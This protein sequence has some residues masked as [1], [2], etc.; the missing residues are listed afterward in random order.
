MTAVIVMEDGTIIYGEKCG[1]EGTAFGELVFNTSMAGYQEVL[2]DPSYNGQI[3][4]MT[5]PMIGNYGC[6][7]LF[8]ES[9]GGP[10]VKAFVM[11]E[12]CAL[13][14][15]WR[16]ESSLGDYLKRHDIVAI[17]EIDTRM[18]TKRIRIHGTLKAVVSTEEKF[19]KEPSL[20]LLKV[21]QVLTSGPHLVREVTTKEK[22]VIQGSGKRVVVL[23]FGIKANILRML[24]EED[25]ELVVMPGYATVE[26][27][28]AEKP[29][30][31]FLSNGPGDPEDVPEAQQVVKYFVGKLPIFGICLGHQIMG[32]SLGAKTYKLK[33]GHRGANHPVQDIAT[34]KVYITSQNHG[35]A[36]DEE[37]IPAE[38]ICTHRNLNDNT[39]EGLRHKEL[40]LFSV[41]YHPEAAPG[42]QD[43]RYLFKQ[44]NQLITN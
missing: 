26:E 25:Y 36:I 31:I 7:E 33:F 9:Q 41:Q 20:L 32:L 24:A 44:F 40:P 8:A 29:Q 1:A 22:Y 42:P 12:N 3:V 28:E 30:A 35:Y 38:L 34:G 39:V 2:T 14:S 19:L 13:P 4:V 16:V 37:S 6:A 17:C 43:S 10:K 5:Y 11:R 23:D 15:N 21:M 18:L 27:V